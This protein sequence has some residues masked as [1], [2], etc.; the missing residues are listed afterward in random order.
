MATVAHTKNVALLTFLFL[1]LACPVVMGLRERKLSATLLDG[2]PDDFE[3]DPFIRVG[4]KLYHFGQSQVSWFKAN[5][6]CQSMGGVLAS[7]DN[8]EEIEELSEHLKSNY[9]NDRWWWLSGS[10]LHSEGDFYWYG[11][12]ER[13]LY[14]DWAGV[15]PDNA[16]GNEHCVHLWYKE[17]K[18]QMNDWKCRMNAFYICQT[19]KPTTV[20]VSVF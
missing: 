17:P 3:T 12:G 14:A 20:V 1:C 18:Y 11:T 7:F 16:G 15:Q 19:K 2:Y 8:P 4:K 10:D 9:P 6:I 5:L 13:M